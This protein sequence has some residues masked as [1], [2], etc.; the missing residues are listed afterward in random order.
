MYNNVQGLLHSQLVHILSLF[1]AF[2]ISAIFWEE[3]RCI[4]PFL[5]TT[6]WG[7]AKGLTYS[8]TLNTLQFLLWIL[9]IHG[10]G[11]LDEC[12]R[13]YV[14]IKLSIDVNAPVSVGQL[15]ASWGRLSQ[16]LLK[17]L[18]VDDVAHVLGWGAET[19]LEGEP[20]IH[21][22]RI[23]SI[24]VRFFPLSFKRSCR[25]RR[26]DLINIRNFSLYLRQRNGALNMAFLAL[27]PSEDWGIINLD[28]STVRSA[29]SSSPVGGEVQN[30]PPSPLSTSLK[31]PIQSPPKARRLRLGFRRN[32]S[33]AELDSKD[34]EIKEKPRAPRLRKSSSSIASDAYSGAQ[35]DPIGFVPLKK[36]NSF[37]GDGAFVVENA[38]TGNVGKK[39]K[40]WRRK[41][42]GTMGEEDT[43]E[44]RDIPVLE[45]IPAPLETEL[46]PSSP[47]RGAGKIISSLSWA[48]RI[49]RAGSFELESFQIPEDTSFDER[50]PLSTANSVPF[51]I[52]PPLS[53][54][55][56]PPP[57]VYSVSAPMLTPL[58][59]RNALSLTASKL[60]MK[61][62]GRTFVDK[63]R[64][65]IDQ[66]G[67]TFRRI[68]GVRLFR[69][70]VPPRRRTLNPKRYKVGAINLEDARL[71]LCPSIWCDLVGNDVGLTFRRDYKL[72]MN[73]G[74]QE[75]TP[76][77][78]MHEGLTAREIGEMVKERLVHMLTKM[79]LQEAF[80]ATTLTSILLGS[81][82]AESRL[83]SSPLKASSSTDSFAFS[84]ESTG[85]AE[86]SSQGSRGSQTPSVGSGASSDW[87]RSLQRMRSNPSEL[88]AVDECVPLGELTSADKLRK[89]LGTIK[90]LILLTV[91]EEGCGESGRTRLAALPPK[92]APSADMSFYDTAIMD[93]LIEHVR[94]VGLDEAYAQFSTI[95]L[96]TFL[97][98]L[99]KEP[100]LGAL[101][102]GFDLEKLAAKT[103]DVTTGGAI[104]TV[105][106]QWQAV[107]KKTAYVLPDAEIL[108]R[109]GM[110]ARIQ[111]Y[112]DGAETEMS[113]P[114]AL[115]PAVAL[116]LSHSTMT[117]EDELNIAAIIK[118]VSA[119]KPQRVQQSPG[120]RPVW[121]LEEREAERLI[122]RAKLA[123]ALAHVAMQADIYQV[124]AAF[125]ALLR[126]A[127]VGITSL[128]I[129][130]TRLEK[131]GLR[132][133]FSNLDLSGLAVAREAHID[134]ATMGV[135]LPR[136]GAR[137]ETPMGPG[138]V[139][140]LRKRTRCF[141][142]HMEWGGTQMRG[143]APVKGYFQPESLIVLDGTPDDLGEAGAHI[144]DESS[145]SVD[146]D[147][148]KAEPVPSANGKHEHRHFGRKTD[149]AKK[150][151][152]SKSSAGKKGAPTQDVSGDSSPQQPPTPSPPP[153]PPLFLLR[154]SNVS[155][156]LKDVQ[157]KVQ[158]VSFP[159][160]HTHGT[161]A[162]L[163]HGLAVLIE[164]EHGEPG[165]D[166]SANLIRLSR[167]KV[168]LGSVRVSI[169]GS[170][171][172]GLY[173][174]V[175]KAFEDAIQGYV[176]MKTEEALKVQ[177]GRLVDVINEQVDGR[178]GVLKQLTQQRAATLRKKRE[179]NASN[180]SVTPN[181]HQQQ[182]LVNWGYTTDAPPP[183]AANL[184]VKKSPSSPQSA[185]A[186]FR[187][188]FI[189]REPIEEIEKRARSSS[190]TQSR[191]NSDVAALAE[192]EERRV[193]SFRSRRPL[194]L[195][196]TGVSNSHLLEEVAKEALIVESA[197]SSAY[198]DAVARR[199]RGDVV[200][201]VSLG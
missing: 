145:A 20:D 180:C 34:Y 172:S 146:A 122:L 54:I 151:R 119:V 118:V 39:S 89:V 65:Y 186:R 189:E 196:F 102:L 114:M 43:I 64:A 29:Q 3:D 113:Q 71:Q 103:G 112:L 49:L 165:E 91:L 93:A 200:R 72:S 128:P 10:V 194:S 26:Y 175:S 33:S 163:I 24:T 154:I 51:M 32:S 121:V 160:L 86:L 82:A 130:R 27:G 69:R 83:S 107:H 23:E 6:F 15:E 31:E 115:L 52:P 133:E 36:H 8:G 181:H 13:V 199:R 70:M 90:R 125:E 4:Q 149:A 173:N 46:G 126:A 179:T 201:H 48:K 9:A 28:G 185:R 191:S 63:F 150:S 85:L 101:K 183:P 129:A 142:V 132:C 123:Q 79:V 109:E 58:S 92:P 161:A 197:E 137:V 25:L 157:W 75:L 1:V 178:W 177:I 195:P 12:W 171:L 140:R 88:S 104:H 77:N 193:E 143:G 84:S 21:V 141:I 37:E 95:R 35:R 135:R 176:T 158:Q 78:S 66:I 61:D 98:S 19:A 38:S 159:Y 87:R 117:G 99:S 40:W 184:D 167:V 73:L 74:S 100:Q 94:E 168:T 2:A 110:E 76:V 192:T 152:S 68:G 155:A 16:V 97:D 5:Q 139:H 30:N 62:L 53:E 156:E 17:N 190:P 67:D 136:C 42:S 44:S 138:I 60:T 7:L 198:I 81:L 111:Q 170:K 148:G 147:A 153:L 108:L 47:P 116:N 124:L 182:K 127:M 57:L 80:R 166:G 131:R 18:H 169:M 105:N 162:A 120:S 106:K 96:S 11:F 41:R 174:L 45:H 187:R 59:G 50:P 14:G 188:R 144:H 134:L 55:L 164:L 56:P 22:I